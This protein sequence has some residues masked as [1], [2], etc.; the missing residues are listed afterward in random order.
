MDANTAKQVTVDPLI[1]W[2]NMQT[3][4]SQEAEEATLGAIII[5]PMSYYDVAQFLEADDFF[6]LRHRYIYTAIQALVERGEPAD[7][8]TLCA[9]LKRNERLAEIG[10][11]AYVTQL[12]KDRKSVV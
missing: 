9:E 3:P 10:G 4:Y 8:L 1:A 7:Y 2:G 12:C 5:D 6:I 11:P